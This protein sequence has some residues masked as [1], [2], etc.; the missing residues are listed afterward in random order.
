M[1][2]KKIL[3]SG[4]SG[5]IG[6]NLIA[7]LS[8][9][10]YQLFG[11][12]NSQKDTL[13]IN[14]YSVDLKDF[15]NLQKT[16][17]HIKPDF[18]FHLGAL[19]D[20]SRDFRTARNCIETNI[21]GTINLL[22]C[23]NDFPPQHLIF[24]STEEVYGDGQIP[25]KEDQPL[26]PPSPYAIS[27]IAG[28]Q[29]CQLYAGQNNK[30]T[31]LRVGTVYG[32][33]QPVR[34]FI[35]SIIIKALADEEILLGTGK[36]KRDYIFIDDVVE[37]LIL[38]LKRKGEPIEIINVGGSK[39]IQLKTLVDQIK[40]I[41]KSKAIIV[42]NSYPDRVLEAD[43]WLSDNQRAAELLNWQPT[44]TLEEGIRK[45]INFYRERFKHYG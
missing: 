33:W 1:I 18:V 32:P 35:P 3:I 11:L 22:E 20:L 40:A 12:V 36:K 24:L 7:K 31:I 16:I 4:A 9:S 23:L 13:P 37:A 45:T 38:S 44:T 39:S 29:L 5:F 10:D 25:Y 42:Y 21:M 43:E 34:R 30:T 27:K 6:K 8:R 15:N 28:E 14:E 26:R 17:N 19:V 41:S 2:K